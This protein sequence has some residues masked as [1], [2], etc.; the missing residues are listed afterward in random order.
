MSQKGKREKRPGCQGECRAGTKCA[1]PDADFVQ[2]TFPPVCVITI[3]Q[4]GKAVPARENY[5]EPRFKMQVPQGFPSKAKAGLLINIISIV[6][7]IIYL[8]YYNCPS[9]NTVTGIYQ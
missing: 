4:A 2:A 8:L 6:G 5:S 3:S 1:F 9:P 7:D